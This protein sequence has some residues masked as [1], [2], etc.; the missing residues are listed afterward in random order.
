MMP[1]EAK[2]TVFVFQ[3]LVKK[4]QRHVSKAD[5]ASTQN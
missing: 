5:E 4:V 3:A 1:I 2:D